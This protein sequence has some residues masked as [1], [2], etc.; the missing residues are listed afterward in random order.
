M[1]VRSNNG[2]GAPDPTSESDVWNNRGA[3]NRC[4]RWGSYD[5]GRAITGLPIWRMLECVS[6]RTGL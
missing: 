1:S 5:H 4:R 3:L 6:R 2:D